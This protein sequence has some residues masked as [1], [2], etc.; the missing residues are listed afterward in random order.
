MLLWQSLV[1]WVSSW[2]QFELKLCLNKIELQRTSSD[3]MI[4]FPASFGFKRALIRA[5]KKGSMKARRELLNA[6]LWYLVSVESETEFE[7]TMWGSG[8]ST[9]NNACPSIYRVL[10]T[11]LKPRLWNLVRVT[12]TSCP[13]KWIERLK[14]WQSVCFC[15]NETDPEHHKKIR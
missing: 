6:W 9:F 11:L 10:I 14:L 12:M 15:D 7:T 1:A 8:Y 13:G 5:I 2:T 4:F 3:A